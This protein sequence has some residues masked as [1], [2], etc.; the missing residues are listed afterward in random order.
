MARRVVFFIIEVLI[1]T[2]P[3]HTLNY[4]IIHHKSEVSN[5]DCK[6]EYKRFS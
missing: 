3:V 4:R 5:P 6:R 2:L 1:P